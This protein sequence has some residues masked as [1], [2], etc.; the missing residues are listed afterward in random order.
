[1]NIANKSIVLLLVLIVVLLWA[2]NFISIAYIVKE[3]DSFTALTLRFAVVALVLSPFIL[4]LPPLKDFMYLVLATIIIVPGHFGLLFLSIKYT[5]SVGGI[6]VLLQLAIPFSLLFSWMFFKDRPSNLRVFGLLI[7]FIGIVFL[8]YDPNLLE[9]KKAF[10]IAIASALCL[11]LYFVIVKKIKKIKSMGIIA[12]S[13]LLGIPMMYIL[14]LLN[15]ESF[16]NL[17]NIQSNYTYYAFFY[18]VIGSSI[19]GHSI[20]AYL[21]KTQDISYISPFLL[22]I[23]IVSVVLSAVIFEEIITISFIIT[24]SVIIFGIF[25]VFISKDGKNLSKDLN[26]NFRKNQKIKS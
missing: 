9:S 7:A 14:M 5:K 24:S 1:M 22:L 3:I 25:L 20:W 13:S 8:L 16:E 21:I 19:L 26:E 2:G 12:W 4:K 10:F 15:N 17:Q 11:G 18:T 23:P 6:S